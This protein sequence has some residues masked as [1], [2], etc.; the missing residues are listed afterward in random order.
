MDEYSATD[1]SVIQTKKQKT[2]SAAAAQK[3]KKRKKKSFHENIR[4]ACSLCEMTAALH[5][6]PAGIRREVKH[7]KHIF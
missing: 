5:C 4:E 2:N 3:Q 1:H 6:C 7:Q